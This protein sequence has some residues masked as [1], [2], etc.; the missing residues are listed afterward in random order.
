M[1]QFA[2]I[3][4]FALIVKFNVNRMVRNDLLGTIDAP[5]VGLPDGLSDICNNNQEHIETNVQ[6]HKTN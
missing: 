3:L 5:F 2:Q 6:L 1:S 4:Q